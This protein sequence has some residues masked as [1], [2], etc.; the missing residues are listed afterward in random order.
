[1][2]AVD[3][4]EGFRGSVSRYL[5]LLATALERWDDAAGHFEEALA[6]NE[7][8]GA[9]PWLARTEDDYARMLLVRGRPGDDERARELRDQAL[10]TFSE[11]GMVPQGSPE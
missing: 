1:M 2:N 8:M 9:R 7:R 5:G 11:L 4:T 6:L 10:A 3:V